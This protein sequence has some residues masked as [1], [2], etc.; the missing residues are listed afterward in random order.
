MRR[1]PIAITGIVFL[2]IGIVGIAGVFV[3]EGTA[4]MPGPL[5]ESDTSSTGSQSVGERIYLQGVGEDGPVRRSGGIGHMGS[6]GCV[7]CHGPDGLGGTVG[8][9]GTFADAPPIT[10]A[11]LTGAHDEHGDSDESE[12]WTDSDISLVIRDGVLPDGDRVNPIMPRWD[13]NA[14]DMEALIEHLKTLDKE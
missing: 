14:S 2:F 10:Y 13:M 12:A 9:M 5:Y 11:A 3:F 1:S 4:L 7:T 6:G 8:M